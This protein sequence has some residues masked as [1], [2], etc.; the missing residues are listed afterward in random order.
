MLLTHFPSKNGGMPYVFL[1]RFVP[2]G[3]SAARTLRRPDGK[4]WQSFGFHG[5]RPESQPAIFGME[6]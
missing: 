2:H 1:S 4:T 3:F 5:A 6:I